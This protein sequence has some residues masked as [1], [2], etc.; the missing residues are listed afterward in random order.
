MRARA[1]RAASALAAM[2]EIGPW[3]EPLVGWSPQPK[4]YRDALLMAC[5]RHCSERV[6]I[7]HSNC[8]VHYGSGLGPERIERLEGRQTF[9]VTQEAIA[10][11]GALIESF[12]R[13]LK[14]ARNDGGQP[15]SPIREQARRTMMDWIAC[16]NYQR[17][18][19]SC[20]I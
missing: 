12:W 15:S 17:Q 20:G 3:R 19:R 11:D 7:F 18:V 6:R 8:C 2:L 9:D 4:P 14:M 1:G 10:A 13:W 5:L 16:Y